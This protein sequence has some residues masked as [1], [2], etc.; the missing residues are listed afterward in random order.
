MNAGSAAVRTLR[1]LVCSV[2]C[3][4]GHGGKIV[5]DVELGLDEVLTNA[6][7]HAQERA[8]GTPVGLTIELYDNRLILLVDD[9]GDFAEEVDGKDLGD[10]PKEDSES[11]RG[12]FLIRQTMD[13]VHFEKREGG[14]TRV[15]L[16]KRLKGRAET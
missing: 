16:I 6:C 13:E 8:P 14:G 3:D 9:S 4:R 11:G 12:L 1:R 10:L 2:L 15:R 7:V 5:E